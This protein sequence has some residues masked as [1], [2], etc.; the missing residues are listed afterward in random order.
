MS[1]DWRQDVSDSLFVHRLLPLH[2]E[3]SL[4]AAFPAKK[5]LASRVI[6]GLPQGSA[7]SLGTLTSQPDGFALHA[8]LRGAERWPAAAPDGDYTG[9]GHADACFA[10]DEEDWS[11]YN[12]L[13]FQVY[14]ETNGADV[15]HLHASLATGAG[16]AYAREGETSFN[17]VPGRWNDCYWEFP[18]LPRARVTCLRLYV[19][20]CG[21][22]AAMDPALRYRFRGLRAE[23]VEGTEHFEGW[24]VAPGHIAFS[25]GGYLA[26]G[27]KEALAQPQDVSV[28]S[29]LA[30]QSG[31]AVFTAPSRKL[32]T[33][34]GDFCSLD[35]SAFTAAG[36]YRL[37][38]G[39]LTSPPFA[40]GGDMPREALYKAVNFLFAERCG[41]PV[42]GRHC[43]CHLDSVARHKGVG[44]SYAGGWH[45]AG[46]V[47]QQ[48]VQTGEAVHA[49]LEAAARCK[50]NAPLRAR[51]LEEAQ[52]G[53]DFVLRTRFGDGYRATS[54]GATRWTDGQTGNMDDVDVRV[55]NHA[56]ENFL[57]SGVEA[58]A[59][60]ALRQDCPALAH[61]SLR[62][63]QE[64]FAFAMAR[65]QA[66]G[67]E[68]PNMYEHTY[69]ASFSQYAAVIAH[70]AALLY[71]QTGEKFYAAAA[72]EYGKHLLACQEQAGRLAGFFYRDE[73]RETIVHFTHQS[74]EHLFMQALDALCAGLP[75]HPDVPA[76]LAA[77]ARY[78]EYL[79]ALA[80]YAAPYG[81]LPAGAYRADEY[82]DAKH[83]PLLHL[84]VS[85]EREK[86]NYRAQLQAAVPAGNELVV[87]C[88][89]V[90]F[91]FRGNTAVHLAMGKAAAIAGRRLGDERLRD[92]GREQLY[93]VLG[94]NP[95]AQSLV[96]G[97]GC[98]YASQYA[99]FPGE[100]TGEIPVGIQTRGNADIPYW[101]QAANATYKE[102]WISAASRW[103]WLLAEYVE[104]GA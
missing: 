54:A 58:V 25:T 42:P 5:V 28:F 98:R 17:L 66:C 8:P 44:L 46:D 84:L 16:D 1:E 43:A 35:F 36:T 90:W 73:R 100:V 12:R 31:K 83:F 24:D 20:L 68:L 76:W 15:A 6:A 2:R 23:R 99:V 56:F 41:T 62:A 82:L 32:T 4:E 63:A 80:P 39:A 52:W 95:F 7:H 89:P 33:D 78:G 51:L 77:M 48:T 57:L 60:T 34:K 27:H 92:M 13:V 30:A 101:P 10:L 21:R 9:F 74:R 53:L 86:E 22:D 79:K 97:M 72:V 69:N 55:H 81:M 59:A 85:Y 40:I 29:L 61:G 102:V 11:G 88:F 65:W 70:S 18:E 14:P 71:S 103:I 104:E 93:W 87:R 50:G 19:L 96:Y 91:S 26:H 47:S 49:L 38:F 3:R 45:D 67:M 94:K 75:D 64:D 37:R